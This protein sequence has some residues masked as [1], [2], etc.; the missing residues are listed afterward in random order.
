MSLEASLQQLM[1]ETVTVAPVTA[2]DAYGKRTWGTATTFSSC[3]VQT[4]NYKV[5][6]SNGQEKV[7]EGR[8]YFPNKPTITLNDKI[9]LPDGSTPPILS[10]DFFGDERGDHHTIVHFGSASA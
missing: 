1:V 10:V 5:L 6:D 9:T 2:K 7:S 4:G 8:V 3:R